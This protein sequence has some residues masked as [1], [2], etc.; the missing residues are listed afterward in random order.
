MPPLDT[1]CAAST[2]WITLAIWFVVEF[3]APPPSPLDTVM[4]RASASAAAICGA[5]IGSISICR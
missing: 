2:V 3:A 1:S 5:M 4:S